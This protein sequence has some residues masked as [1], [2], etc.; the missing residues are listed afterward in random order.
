MPLAG[1]LNQPIVV[2][3]WS[4]GPTDGYGN[5]TRAK[6]SEYS[7]LG[8]LEQTDATEVAVDRETFVSNWLLV[9]PAGS[10]IDGGDRVRYDS[11][12]YEVV[13]QPARPWNPRTRREDHV[14]VRLRQVT[15]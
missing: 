14:E 4:A 12:S 8:Y 1:L 11:D 3:R 15:G 2:E 13:G 9:L 6:A 10:A 5:P 7:V